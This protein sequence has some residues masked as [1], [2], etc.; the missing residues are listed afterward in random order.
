M[1]AITIQSPLEF[2]KLHPNFDPF[3][4]EKIFVSLGIQVSKIDVS[5]KHLLAMNHK[6]ICFKIVLSSGHS[7]EWL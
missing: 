5:I 4:P 7:G 1:G 3:L 6:Y 2:Y